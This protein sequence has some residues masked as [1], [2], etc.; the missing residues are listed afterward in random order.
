MLWPERQPLGG[1]LRNWLVS[2][3]VVFTGLSHAALS[4]QQRAPVIDMHNAS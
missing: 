3:L 4:A 1:C 2:V